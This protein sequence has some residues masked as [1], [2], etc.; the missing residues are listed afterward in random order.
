MKSLEGEI[1]HKPDLY[2]TLE[3]FFPANMAFSVHLQLRL[4]QTELSVEEVLQNRTLK[5]G[6]YKMS[7]APCA[8]FHAQNEVLMSVNT[9]NPLIPKGD[10]V[11]ISPYNITLE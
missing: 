6:F 2:Q 4:M 5:V 8:P 1:I 11:L 3:G 10:K 7:F 9:F